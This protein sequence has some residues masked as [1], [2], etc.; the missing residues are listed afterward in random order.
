MQELNIKALIEAGAHFGH[1]AGRWNPKMAPY[2]HARR[3]KIHILDL[4]ETVKG[5]LR[6]TH[7]VRE[8]AARG[9]DI[10]FI[11][12]KRQAKPIIKREA[13]RAGM[14][15]V[16]ERWLG[17]TLTN[18]NTIRR[19]LRRLAEL[20]AMREEGGTVGLKKKEV[21]RLAREERKIRRNLE[22]IKDLARPP[23]ALIIIDPRIEHIAIK[24]AAKMGL[25]VVAMLDTDCDPSKVDIVV[26]A[27]DDS[28]R[29]IDIVVIRL[30]DAALEGRHEYVV[31]QQEA[32][33]RGATRVTPESFQ[34]V[35]GEMARPPAGEPAA[36][37]TSTPAASPAPEAAAAEV[38]AA[39]TPA[40]ETP[41]AE[42]PPADAPAT[43][44]STPEAEAS[45]GTE[46]ESTG[47]ESGEGAKA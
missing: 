33:A 36:A 46:A 30:A 7:F 31:R 35:E 40:A 43:E 20:E 42:A 5:I 14:P 25:P 17:G 32:A 19:R 26:P 34:D 41:A 44:A 23:G 38:P 11:G 21:S 39:E 13:I 28:I 4:R 29:A 12:T 37:V 6:A 8:M 27:N 22:G 10:L 3:N 2:I 45:A 24:E 9:E 16:T 1:R 18:F 47:E 15:Y